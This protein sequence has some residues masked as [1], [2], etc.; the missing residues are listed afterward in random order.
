MS[1]NRCKVILGTQYLN[2]TNSSIIDHAIERGVAVFDTADCYGKD[3]ASEKEL[4]AVLAKYPREKVFIGTKCGV[5]FQN[6]TVCT[7]GSRDYLIQGCEASLA[8]L[9]TDYIDLFSLHRVGQNVP[10]EESMQAMKEL[11]RQGKIRGVGLSEVT[12]DQIRRAHNIHP[13]EAVQ[14]E[15]SPWAR[16]DEFNGVV[17]TCH[18]LNIIVT[19][20]SPLGRA[21]F[22]DVSPDYF[23]SLSS[24]DFRK[25]LP[26]YNGEL[27]EKNLAARTALEAYAKSKGMTL[28]QI[29]LAW[30]LSKN[31]VPV[32]GTHNKL[33]FDENMA[34]LASHLT[35]ED[36]TELEGLIDALSFAGDRYPGPEV[37]GIFPEPRFAATDRLFSLRNSSDNIIPRP[38]CAPDSP[39]ML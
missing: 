29:V 33:H 4:G 17:D 31:V 16:E 11:V 13:V 19:G 37:S 12:A 25:R 14:I 18:E 5:R 32:F 23:C 38:H 28:A 27:L 1:T 6:K 20:Y 24:N 7:D 35:K 9:N 3:G 36:L 22:C 34:A 2:D 26:R 10:I 8:R 15:F 39:K 30:E 21:F